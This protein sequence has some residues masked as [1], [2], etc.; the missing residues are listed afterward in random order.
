[1]D[2]EV[3]ER[4][5]FAR[6][7]I[8]KAG[9]LAL[10]YSRRIATLDIT[11]KGVQD[12][13]SEADLT[14]EMLIKDAL[15][16]SCPTDAFLGEETGHAYLPGSTGIWVVDP[17]DGTQPFLSGLPYWC[18]TMAYVRANDL[19]F[20]VVYNPTADELFT[21]GLDAP[22]LLNDRLI[23]PHPGRRLTDGLTF[24][25]CSPRVTADRVVPILDR[26]LR[27]GGMF[28]RTGSGA[29]G[30]CDVAC[31][32]L[33]GYVEPHLNSWDCLGG[34]AVL[35]AAGARVSDFLAGDGLLRGNPV[36]AGPPALYDALVE[37]LG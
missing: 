15:L 6:E 25:G 10:D 5:A 31:G 18:I 29:L 13:V 17:I 8:V 26:L 28:V 7:L 32:R 4:F 2:A 23:R 3:A 34:I 20:G 27:A 19:Q 9:R 30:L 24:L 21:G 36:V 35:Q 12:M 1:M 22:A 16:D 11:A 14:V 37:V 33:I